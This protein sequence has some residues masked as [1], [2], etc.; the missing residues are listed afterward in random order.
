MLGIVT[1][2]RNCSSDVTHP[3]L[4]NIQNGPSPERP[5]SSA[6]L[7]LEEEEENRHGGGGCS[8][9]AAVPAWLHRARGSEPLQRPSLPLRARG[10]ARAPDSHIIL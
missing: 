10:D 4:D 7:F 8:G 5:L 2:L 9:E 3:G 1:G 6:L